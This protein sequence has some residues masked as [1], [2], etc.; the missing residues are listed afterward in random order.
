MRRISSFLILYVLAIL[1][2]C[3]VAA[4]AANASASSREACPRPAP[5]SL[6]AEPQDLRSRNG[7]LKVDLAVRNSRQSDGSLRYCYVL[8]D[9]SQSPTLRLQP[10]DLL[11]LRLK[12]E[13]LDLQADAGDGAA[14]GKH[15]HHAGASNLSNPCTSGLMSLTSTNLDRKSVV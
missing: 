12:N 14:A 6:V 1:A 10:G 9:G 5:G 8:P 11:V 3:P 13:L 2:T 15:H 4:H 7:M